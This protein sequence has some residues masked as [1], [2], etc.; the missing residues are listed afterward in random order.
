MLKNFLLVA[1]IIALTSA[2]SASAKNLQ[3][4]SV[5]TTA[6][7]PAQLFASA[8]TVFIRSNTGFMK[9][10]SLEAALLDRKG[11]TELGFVITKEESLADLIIDVDHAHMQTR[12]PFSVVDTKTRIVVASGNVSSLFGTVAGKIANSFIKQARN[13]RQAA[14]SSSKR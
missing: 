7:S 8:R 10:K 3:S 13:A 6:K 11:F 4:E 1:I 9:R 2:A 14:G 5:T 12:F